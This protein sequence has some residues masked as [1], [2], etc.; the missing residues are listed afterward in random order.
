MAATIRGTLAMEMR[1]EL[2]TQFAWWKKRAAGLIFDAFHG[3]DTGGSIAAESL[4]I[5]S[6]NRDKGIAYDP[7]PWST[8]RQS[9]RLACL[10]AEGFTFVDI[11]CGKG[12]VLL[13]AMVLPFERIIGV[14]FS[15]YLSRIA[16]QNIASARFLNRKC[17]Y[18]EIVC[19]DAVH[20]TIAEEPTIFF[21]ANPFSYDIMELVL[22]NIVSSYFRCPRQIFLV[23]Y[24]TSTIMPQ[25]R[26]FLPKKS[27]GQARHRVSSTVGQRSVNIFELPQEG[28]AACRDLAR[29]HSGV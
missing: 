2:R 29:V 3:V 13:S 5:V 26:E 25:I 8:L 4:E 9:L 11:G 7:C 24:A 1:S 15:F 16:E 12:K 18:V 10:R 6:A 22:G 21:F 20:Y 17:P 28:Q 23:F 19:A 14:E 27:G